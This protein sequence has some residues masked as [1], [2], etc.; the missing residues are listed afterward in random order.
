MKIFRQISRQT[1]ERHGLGRAC[2]SKH[3]VSANMVDGE[4]DALNFRTSKILSIGALER[5][6]RCI[7]SE[8]S[9]NKG[10]PD[11]NCIGFSFEA[12]HSCIFMLP[13]LFSLHATQGELSYRVC[14]GMVLVSHQ[15]ACALEYQNTVPSSIHSPWRWQLQCRKFDH[16]HTKRITPE[17]RGYKVHF[18]SLSSLK[19]MN[20]N[21]L[22]V[23]TRIRLHLYSYVIIIFVCF[24]FY[25][26]TYFPSTLFTLYIAFIHMFSSA[27]QIGESLFLLVLRRTRPRFRQRTWLHPCK[28]QQQDT[29]TY[30]VVTSKQ[31][32]KA[33]PRWSTNNFEYSPY[34]NVQWWSFT[35]DTNLLLQF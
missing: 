7:H 12:W 5:L 24:V 21:P 27:S 34:L 25:F 22:H 33:A 17:N 8:M 18:Y 15:A 30:R 29:I 14:R 16:Q 6:T 35:V 31:E 26:H 23:M 13:C 11:F 2:S 1:Y 32:W 20:F 9:A 4:T 28:S 10:L 19:N 3:V